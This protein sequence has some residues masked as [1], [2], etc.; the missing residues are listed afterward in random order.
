[1]LIKPTTSIQFEYVS[2][3]IRE[4]YE[5]GASKERK[6]EKLMW[7][8]SDYRTVCAERGNWCRS[9]PLIYYDSYEEQ[10]NAIVSHWIEK[11]ECS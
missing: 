10:K 3:V 9:T 1:M 2:G 11:E 6:I 8:G 7:S 4:C 5:P